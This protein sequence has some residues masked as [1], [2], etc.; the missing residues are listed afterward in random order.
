MSKE[1]LSFWRGGIRH[2]RAKWASWPSRNGYV[3]SDRPDTVSGVLSSPNSVKLSGALKNLLRVASDRLASLS[4]ASWQCRFRGR[5]SPSVHSP[6][7][8]P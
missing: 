7:H 4:S 3:S 8:L 6:R 2:E 1:T 5:C